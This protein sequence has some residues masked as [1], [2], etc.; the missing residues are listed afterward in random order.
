MLILVVRYSKKCALNGFPPLTKN[1]F[2]QYHYIKIKLQKR[3]KY[4]YEMPMVFACAN[5]SIF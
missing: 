2:V 5:L 4:A 1:L 3:T